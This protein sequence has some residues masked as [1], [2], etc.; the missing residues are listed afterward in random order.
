MIELAD[1]LTAA[2]RESLSTFWFPLGLWTLFAI[3]ISCILWLNDSI[4]AAYQLHSRTAL[5]VTLPLGIA[6]SALVGFWTTLSGSAI[7][8][9]V[10]FIVIQNPITVAVSPG[11][12]VMNWLNPFL[13]MGILLALLVSGSLAAIFYLGRNL[14][15]LRKYSRLNFNPVTSVLKDACTPTGHQPGIAFSDEV[16]I[17]FTYGWFRTRIVMPKSLRSQNQKLRLAIKHELMHIKHR[18][19]LTNNLLAFIRCVFWFHPLTHILHNQCKEYREITCDS[20]VL[21]DSTV[22]KKSYAEL[23]Y[24][25]ATKRL[26]DNQMIVSMAVNSSTLKKRIKMMNNQPNKSHKKSIFLMGFSALFMIGIISCSDLQQNGL[27]NQE[28]KQA[29]VEI[30]Q[31][32]AENSP[33]FILNG[34]RYDS[35]MAREVIPRIKSKYIKSITV[36]K[37]EKATSKYGE[38]G[39]YGVI[40]IEL[41]ALDKA[42]SDLMRQPP[43]PPQPGTRSE[44]DNYFVAV[45]EM[46]ELIGGLASLQKKIDYPEMARNA[47]IEGRVIVQFIVNEQGEVENAQVIRGIGGGADKEA[48]HVVKQAKFTPGKQNGQAVRVQYSLP[49]TF[50]LSEK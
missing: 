50:K 17:P 33:L 1:F 37:G 19:F 4:P 24:E 3:T 31:Q 13:W 40:E 15:Q 42:L 47:G 12:A 21:S 28:V 8:E 5:L 48:L 11:T 14:F 32:S 20:Q 9:G 25:L 29:Q 49:I 22:S 27:T 44:Q 6:G 38:E 41:N 10:K 2:G 35:P 7:S 16:Q 39:K 26:S 46:P 30:S 18:D 23:L 36:L 43:P 34:E 45:E